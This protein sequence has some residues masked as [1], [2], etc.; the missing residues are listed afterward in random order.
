MEEHIPM[1]GKAKSHYDE[2]FKISVEEIIS[3]YAEC[4]ICSEP[5][6]DPHIT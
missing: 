5:Y 4:V 1:L 2:T 3:R 6:K